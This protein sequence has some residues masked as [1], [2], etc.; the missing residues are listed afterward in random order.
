MKLKVKG[1]KTL[2]GL[3]GNLRFILLYKFWAATLLFGAGLLVGFLI[4]G[5][6][7]ALAH[8]GRLDKGICHQEHKTSSWHYHFKGSSNVAGLCDGNGP[9]VAPAQE[10]LDRLDHIIQMMEKYDAERCES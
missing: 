3:K 2:K 7:A 8:P 6:A 5:S 4:W 1:A 10:I 9:L